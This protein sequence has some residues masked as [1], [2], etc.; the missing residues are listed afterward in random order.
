M[1]PSEF[2]FALK[3]PNLYGSEIPKKS[4]FKVSW[5]KNSNILKGNGVV[6]N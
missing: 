1:W 5:F 6:N 3:N 2:P 4:K